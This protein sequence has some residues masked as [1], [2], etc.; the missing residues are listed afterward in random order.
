M[1]NGETRAVL[2]RLRSTFA[3]VML[4]GTCALVLSAAQPLSKDDISLLLI[5]GASEQKM[6]VL[7]KQRG[8]DFQLT[9]ELVKK[10]HDQGATDAVID[11]IVQSNRARATGSSN[12][13][14]TTQHSPEPQPTGPPPNIAPEVNSGVSPELPGGGAGPKIISLPNTPTSTSPATS[15][16]TGP[17]SEGPPTTG[18]PAS[19][20]A[21]KS[22]PAPDLRDPSPERI[23]QIIQTFAAK[24][25]QFKEA[26]DN[27]TYHQINK[28]E[29]LDADGSVEG[30]YEQDWDILFDDSGKRIEHVTYAPLPS[31]KNLMVTEQDLNA[32]RSIQPFVLTTAELPDYEIQ[33]LG[34]VK[35]D[36]IT[37]YVF[38]VR[39]KEIRKGHQYF[40]GVVWVD[41]RDLQIVKAEGKNVPELKTKHG[42]NLFPRFTT[43][44]QQ[45]DGKYWF[46][47]F[48]LADD[49]LYFSSGPIHIREIIRYTDYKQF[50]STSRI[51]AVAPD[52][53]APK[54]PA[55][56]K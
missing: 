53:S 24:E 48:T 46:P 42:E 9:P 40:K 16:G 32:F 41:D 33:Y 13:A 12:Q 17:N 7:I 56:K 21:A 50:K 11:A 23:Q 44:R 34:H 28:V 4:I 29:E 15:N 6:I 18:R 22:G 36:Y 26:R 19:P 39:P 5:G 8:V 47:T 54:S 55:P 31:L 10:F 27:Y 14:T 51:L 38:S 43:W 30:R 37:A 3:V 35:V 25:E 20:N 1:E 52:N 2:G 45:I 49:T